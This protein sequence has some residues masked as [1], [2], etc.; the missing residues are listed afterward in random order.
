MNRHT[1]VFKHEGVIAA[2][3][4]PMSTDTQINIDPI[5]EYSEFLQNN[6]VNGVFVNGTTGECSVL[7]MS[8]RSKGTPTFV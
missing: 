2:V 7:S 6:G 4:T 8:E 5:P 3:Y 1:P